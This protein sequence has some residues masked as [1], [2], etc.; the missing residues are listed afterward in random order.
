LGDFILT[1]P[2]LR[3]LNRRGDVALLTRAAYRALLPDWL[4]DSP[5][6]SVD[7]LPGTRLFTPGVSLPAPLA[8]HVAG[9]E[10]HIFAREDELLRRNLER[11]GANR[12][13]FHDPRPEAP[14]HIVERFFAGA[15]IQPPPDW[16]EHPAMPTNQPGDALWIHAGSG[17][18]AKDLPIPLLAE[19]ARHW[20]ET[21]GL[22]VLVSFGE[23][24]LERR[25]PLR[26]TFLRERIRYTEVVNPSLGELRELLARRA[27]L[28]LGADTGVT[29]LAAALG[30]KTIV[31]YRTTDPAVWRPVGNC[32]ALL[33]NQS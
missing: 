7:G 30:K 25:E 14:P 17:S 18:P 6:L 10:I 8:E 15:G 1:L 5:F 27:R 16:L 4:A 11:N 22:P 33:V 26:Q 32:T 9:A 28:F 24:D 29:H 13:V 3:E 23:A 31:G 12:I 21:A 20:L 2:L 19:H